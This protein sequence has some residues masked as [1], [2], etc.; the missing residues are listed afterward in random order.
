MKKV[1]EWIRHNQGAAVSFLVAGGLMIWIYGCESKVESLV[2]PGKQVN[3]AELQVEIDFEVSRLR[4]EVEEII[5]QG[6]LKATDIQR[7]DELKSKL[8]NFLA[9]TVDAGTINP[10]GVVGML[11]SILG[12]GAVIDNRIKDKVI[13]NRPLKVT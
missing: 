1:A 8:V 4:L 9:I 2:T 13:K 10:A 7:M 5:A 11:F 6:K 12:V 3:A